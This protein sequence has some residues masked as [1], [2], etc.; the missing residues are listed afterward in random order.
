VFS[1]LPTAVRLE[2]EAL[3]GRAKLA[4]MKRAE[5]RG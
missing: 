1:K 2:V 3:G 4:R 5:L